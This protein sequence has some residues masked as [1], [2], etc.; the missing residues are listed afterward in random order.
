MIIAVQCQ[1]FLFP[2]SK[3]SFETKSSVSARVIFTGGSQEMLTLI[4]TRVTC[5]CEYHPDKV[6]HNSENKCEDGS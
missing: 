5:E 6:P 3:V 1:F 4:L 2:V